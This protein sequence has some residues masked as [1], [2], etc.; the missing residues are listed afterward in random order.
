MST[1]RVADI[2]KGLVATG[3]PI[4]VEGWVRT[5]RDTKAGLSFVNVSD[6]SSFN[7]LQVIAEQTLPNYESEI[8]RLTTGCSVRVV[9]ELVQSP[10][11]K[12]ALEL[13]AERVEVVGWIDD[14]ETYPMQPKRHS[15]EFLRE[16]AQDGKR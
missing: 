7:P 8:K 3:V 11:A 16:Q 5:R 15:P 9:G 2:L 1:H 6:G 12:Q 4:T 14:P 10:G 13:R